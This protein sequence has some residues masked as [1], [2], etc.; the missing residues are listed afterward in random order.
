MKA[1]FT[2]QSI[3][4][5]RGFTLVEVQIAVA[6]IA[7]VAAIALPQVCRITDQAGRAKE[8]MNAQHLSTISA[9]AAAGGVVF[10]D[11]DS[12][13]RQLTTAE[14]AVVAGGSLAGSRYR[15]TSL[16][17][18]EVENAKRHLL[19]ANGQLTVVP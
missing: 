8:K 1:L 6:V 9:A 12:A 4:G 18:V 19:F 11:L 14:G 7:L 3:H 13:V 2:L 10:T 17:P 16:S 5:E 15:L